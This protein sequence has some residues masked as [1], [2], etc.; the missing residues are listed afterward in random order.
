MF[1]E[2]DSVTATTGEIGTEIIE[3]FC[4]VCMESGNS[5][6]PLMESHQCTQCVK[7]AWRICVCCNETRLSRLCPVCRGDY[8]PLVLYIM[9]GLY[10]KI[11]KLTYY[12][13]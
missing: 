5:E 1:L 4:I 11:L 6:N 3:E 8:A 7:G 12:N 9:P 2:E 10:S 13:N